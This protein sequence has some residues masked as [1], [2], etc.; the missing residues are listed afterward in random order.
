MN[1]NE[2]PTN[3]APNTEEIA[4]LD[5][6]ATSV[7]A[8]PETSQTETTTINVETPQGMDASISVPTMKE[9]AVMPKPFVDPGYQQA[10]GDHWGNTG[11]K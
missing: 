2:M 6:V 1:N 7:E 4:K 5:P 11:S 10:I 3:V 9:P 8:T